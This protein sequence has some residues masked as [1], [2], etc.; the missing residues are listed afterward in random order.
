MSVPSNII[1]V[2]SIIIINI[3]SISHLTTYDVQDDKYTL[4]YFFILCR[5]MKTFQILSDEKKFV[6]N[7]SYQYSFGIHLLRS[8]KITTGVYTRHLTSLSLLSYSYHSI[9]K[10]VFCCWITLFNCSLI[11]FQ[12]VENLC[13]VDLFDFL[14]TINLIRKIPLIRDR[15]FDCMLWDCKNKIKFTNY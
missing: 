6:R 12:K 3:L 4:A 8:E 5:Q 2:L 15:Y 7:V 14:I 10:A 13:L 1:N 11:L 9:F